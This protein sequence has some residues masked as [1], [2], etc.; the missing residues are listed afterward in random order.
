MY[1]ENMFVLLLVSDLKGIFEVCRVP[2]GIL[3]GAHASS[4]HDAVVCKYDGDTIVHSL[5]KL[6]DKIASEL[7]VVAL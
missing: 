5:S 6:G 2:M 1:F 7:D 4:P 3:V